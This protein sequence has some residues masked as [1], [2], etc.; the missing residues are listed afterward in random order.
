MAKLYLIGLIVGSI[1]VAFVTFLTTQAYSH[2]SWWGLALLAYFIYCFVVGG[3]LRTVLTLA[4]I[5]LLL[6]VAYLHYGFWGALLLYILIVLT[7]ELGPLAR[8]IRDML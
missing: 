1:E 3:T 6:T 8:R 4:I 7:L 5:A 2:N